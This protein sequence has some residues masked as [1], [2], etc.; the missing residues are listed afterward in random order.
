MPSA[1]AVSTLGWLAAAPVS[2]LTAALILFVVACVSAGCVGR[3]RSEV[4]AARDAYTKCVAEH[5]ES[6]PE[7]LSLKARL[8]EAQRVYEEDAR[9][10]WGCDPE[11]EECP[12]SR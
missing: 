4:R 1:R 2:R 11:R 10:A 6:H 5:D 9:R 12:R 3:Q 7:C 8:L